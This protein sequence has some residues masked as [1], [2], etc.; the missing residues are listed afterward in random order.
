VFSALEPQEPS[1]PRETDIDTLVQMSGSLFVYAATSLRFIGTRDPVRQMRILL[2]VQQA[3]GTKPYAQLDKLYIQI[4]RNGLP[5]DGDNSVADEEVDRFQRVIGTLVLLRDPLSLRA[6]SAFTKE[7][8]RDVAF[9]LNYLQSVVIIPSSP[10]E[11]LQIYHPSFRDFLTIPKRCSESRYAIELPSMEKQLTLR[12]LNLLVD[13]LRR[14]V[15]NLGEGFDA[16][17]NEKINDLEGLLQS[18]FPTEVR[19]A[20]LHWYSHLSQVESGDQDVVSLL[21]TFASRYLLFW[22][23]A[24]SLL[25][26]TSRAIAAMRDAHAWTV[27]MQSVLS[28]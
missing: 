14:D 12:C 21:Y 11:P 23:E 22:F 4:L 6:L 13:Y 7:A 24:M 1:W 28:K 27:S 15:L 9:T 17:L 25:K 16:L 8:P 26:Q 18:A 20:C 5:I 2:G 3:S 10:D 19:Y